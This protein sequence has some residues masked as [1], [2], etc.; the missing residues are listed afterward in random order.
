MPCCTQMH[1]SMHNARV[2]SQEGCIKAQ[3][4]GLRA[5]G[6]SATLTCCRDIYFDFVAELIDGGSSGD[7]LTRCAPVGG[8]VLQRLLADMTSLPASSLADAAWRCFQM[9]NAQVRNSCQLSSQ[10]ASFG[11]KMVIFNYFHTFHTHGMCSVM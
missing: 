10:I 6:S 2:Q 9:A 4:S 5:L 3:G 11:P 1:I 8:A 7:A